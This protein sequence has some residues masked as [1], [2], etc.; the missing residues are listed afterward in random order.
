MIFDGREARARF[1]GDDAIAQIEDLIHPGEIDHE[2]AVER[3]ALAVVARGGA[4]RRDR[5][6]VGGREGHDLAKLFEIGDFNRGGGKPVT[7]AIGEDGRIPIKVFGQRFE[8]GTTGG[9]SVDADNRGERIDD[10]RRE[11]NESGRGH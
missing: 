7:D 6:T 11:S 8:A 9:D 1:R 3:N 10:V 5:Y 4:S 2:S